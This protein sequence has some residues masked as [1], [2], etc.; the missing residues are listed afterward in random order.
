MSRLIQ[1]LGFLMNK[2]R[3]AI[4]TGRI[5][6][7]LTPESHLMFY[8]PPLEGK[9]WGADLPKSPV[10]LNPQFKGAHPID[11]FMIPVGRWSDGSAAPVM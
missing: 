6:L 4:K 2:S 11:M 1:V 7:L 8:A 9:V 5:V 10:M 3:I